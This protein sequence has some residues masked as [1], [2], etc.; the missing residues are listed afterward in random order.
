VNI[1]QELKEY[2]ISQERDVDDGDTD[3]EKR[4]TRHFMKERRAEVESHN[5]H[6][7]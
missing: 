1:R 7:C 3:G 4:E 2:D 6:S 5:A